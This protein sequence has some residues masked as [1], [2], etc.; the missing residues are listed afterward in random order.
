MIKIEHSSGVINK[1]TATTI[2]GA[3]REASKQLTFDGGSVHV[4]DTKTGE[5]W[6]R[7]FWRSI[8]RFGW[9]KW[10]KIS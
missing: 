2:T 8:N 5:T 6:S 4:Y 1:A 9:D 3:K 10:K 7:V